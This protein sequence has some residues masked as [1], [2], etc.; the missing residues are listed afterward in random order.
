M[1]KYDVI[2]RPVFSTIRICIEELDENGIGSLVPSATI[3]AFAKSFVGLVMDTVD[4]CK[5][6]EENEQ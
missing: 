1:K 4:A 6:L 5:K 2:F 3:A